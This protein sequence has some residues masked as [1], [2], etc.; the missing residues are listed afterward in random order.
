MKRTEFIRTALQDY[1]VGAITKSSRY[2]IAS[3][4]RQIPP[5]AKKVIEYG[6]GDGIVTK[7]ILTMLLPDSVLIAVDMNQEFL[8]HL[9]GIEDTRLSVIDG[10]VVELSKDFSRFGGTDADVVVSSI[11]FTFLAT[12]K[13]EELIRNTKKNLNPTGRYIVFQY[14]LLVLPLLKKYF[15]KVN[16]YYELRNLPPYFIMVAE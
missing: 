5:D 7:E 11:P 6:A 12:E 14:S 2:T 8:E 3:V 16:V 15:K 13:R 4:I 10:D 9:R 1:R